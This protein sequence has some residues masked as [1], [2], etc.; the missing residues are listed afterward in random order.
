[1]TVH[2]QEEFV[3]EIAGCQSTQRFM[4]KNTVMKSK[5]CGAFSQWR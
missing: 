5:Y 2:H 1:M 4:C 3:V